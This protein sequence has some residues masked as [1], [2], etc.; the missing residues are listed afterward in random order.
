M[1]V[2]FAAAAYYEVLWQSSFKPDVD[3]GIQNEY[4]SMTHNATASLIKYN[5]TVVNNYK[6]TIVLKAV[7]FNT[8]GGI[9]SNGKFFDANHEIIDLS[10]SPV[11]AM[12]QGDYR[13]FNF[14]PKLRFNSVTQ[15]GPGRPCQVNAVIILIFS[16]PQITYERHLSFFDPTC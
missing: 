1:C 7:K 5:V 16:S 9:W 2:L 11:A 10:F 15:Y 3:L 4:R 13:T 6:S 14:G 8:I 12:P